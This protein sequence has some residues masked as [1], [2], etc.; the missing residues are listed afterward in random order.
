MQLSAFLTT[1]SCFDLNH[2]HSPM[3]LGTAEIVFRVLG[4]FGGWRLD[5]NWYSEI[6]F[7]RDCG[8]HVSYFNIPSRVY[9][10]RTL[11]SFVNDISI[12]G[13]IWCPYHLLWSEISDWG[14]S[15]Q[16]FDLECEFYVRTSDKNLFLIN[17]DVHAFNS[18]GT[19]D[20]HAACCMQYAICK[21]PLPWYWLQS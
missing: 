2:Y 1:L 3:H 6:S 9:S 13:P 19:E 14:R 4:S 18:R 20:Q 11:D 7:S 16:P 10:E 8:W 17:N 12:T 5:W 15:W 21:V